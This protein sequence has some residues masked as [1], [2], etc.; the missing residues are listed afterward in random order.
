MSLAIDCVLID[1]ND[2]QRMSEFW[3]SVLT[4]EHVST[5][6]S[7]G[8]LLVDKQGTTRLGLMPSSEE[9]R[10]KTE[11]TSTFARTI[12]KPRF[13]AFWSSA[14]SRLTSINEMFPGSSWQIQKATS[15]ASCDRDERHPDAS[16]T[17]SIRTSGSSRCR[18]ETT[19]RPCPGDAGE[20]CT[21]ARGGHARRQDAK[22][23]RALVR[24]MWAL[25]VAGVEL[26]RS[27]RG[28]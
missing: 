4:L 28:G 16:R 25:V 12:K 22:V 20:W 7:G 1:C 24:S 19:E 14:L 9:K 15:F 21:I 17:A 23:D 26:S 10:G 11:S 8:Y 6:P 2:L 18:R 5:G 3:R 27:P 13:N